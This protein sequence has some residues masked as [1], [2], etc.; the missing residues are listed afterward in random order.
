LFRVVYQIDV[1]AA[2]A[3][4]AAEDAHETMIAPWASRPILTVIDDRGDC[5]EI[6]LNDAPDPPEDEVP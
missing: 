1:N 6:D 2:N 5:T 4:A 3:E